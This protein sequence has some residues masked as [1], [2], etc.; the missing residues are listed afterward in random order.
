[1]KVEWTRLGGP[2]LLL[3]GAGLFWLI[4]DFLVEGVREHDNGAGDAFVLLAGVTLLG[5]ALLLGGRRIANA[6]TLEFRR[7]RDLLI[8]LGFMASVIAALFAVTLWPGPDEEAVAAA[9]DPD[10]PGNVY[11]PAIGRDL[12]LDLPKVDWARPGR[13]GDKDPLRDAQLNAQ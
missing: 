3:I 5:L 8:V 6:F 12:R 7:R 10:A 1:M 9:I 11:E 13:E 2:I 4:G